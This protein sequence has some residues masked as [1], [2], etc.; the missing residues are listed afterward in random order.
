MMFKGTAQ[1]SVASP[2]LSAHQNLWPINQQ[3][4]A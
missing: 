2:V 4:E 1:V 3:V